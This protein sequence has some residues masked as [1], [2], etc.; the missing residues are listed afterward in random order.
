MIKTL[1]NNTKITDC[2][3]M[4]ERPS[5]ETPLKHVTNTIIHLIIKATYLS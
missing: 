3:V 4:M 1:N 2:D 5:I